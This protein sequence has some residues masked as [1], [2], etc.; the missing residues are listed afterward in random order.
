ALA[1]E[2][3]AGEMLERLALAE[4]LARGEQ[5]VGTLSGGMDQAVI[6]L[7]RPGHALRL[8]FF[9]LRAR[10]VAIPP[11]APFV[12]AHSLGE[13]PKAGRARGLYN[14]RVIECRLACATLARRL[15]REL[16]HLGDLGDP[17]AVLGALDDLLPDGALSRAELVSR[18][19]LPAR[20]IERI[21][22]TS[23]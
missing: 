23:V 21:V 9:P 14:Q 2:G 7:G 3:L 16:R 15:G 19:D 8:D 10:P 12:V 17:A 11:D 4:R 20:E 18:L 6:L 5:F 22:P 1:L 13:A